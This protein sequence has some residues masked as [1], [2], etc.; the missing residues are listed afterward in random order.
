MGRTSTQIAADEY[1]HLISG[2]NVGFIRSLDT[3]ATPQQNATGVQPT[4]HSEEQKEPRDES[5][6]VE[7]K[8]W[9]ERGDSNPHGFTRQILSLVRLPI[10]PLSHV[11]NQHVS[12]GCRSTAYK[13]VTI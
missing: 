13:T 3:M 1:V 9:C 7:E 10:P 11:I 8:T 4:V 12:V 2:R 5:E 6:V